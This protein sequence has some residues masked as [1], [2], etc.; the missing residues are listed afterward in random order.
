MCAKYRNEN[1]YSPKR[2]FVELW[3]RILLKQPLI[4]AAQRKES[5]MKFAHSVYRNICA[6]IVLRYL[7]S[8]SWYNISRL[9]TPS[10]ILA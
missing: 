3:S 6:H 9:S 10:N 1:H 8:A 5:Q 2:V 7:Y 4:S